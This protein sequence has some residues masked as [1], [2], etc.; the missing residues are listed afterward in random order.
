MREP[1]GLRAYCC[2]N[3]AEIEGSIDTG[4]INNRCPLPDAPEPTVTITSIKKGQPST[5]EPEDDRLA[6]EEVGLK[7]ALVE[8]A[9]AAY[10]YGDDVNRFPGLDK[11]VEHCSLVGLIIQ[12]ILRFTEAKNHETRNA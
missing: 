9:E 7:A 6:I 2:V 1:S 8:L 10:K 5:V 12:D 3:Q 4:A 11:G